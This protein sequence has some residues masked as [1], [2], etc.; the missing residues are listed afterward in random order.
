MP[1]MH[2]GGLAPCLYQ[3]PIAACQSEICICV[4]CLVIFAFYCCNL[5]QNAGPTSIFCAHGHEKRATLLSDCELPSHPI[6]DTFCVNCCFLS[7]TIVSC[8]GGIGLTLH[9]KFWFHL[10]FILYKWLYFQACIYCT[11]HVNN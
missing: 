4:S 9:N 11:E 3:F 1:A 6:Y 8:H 2:S 10:I 7:N 5:D